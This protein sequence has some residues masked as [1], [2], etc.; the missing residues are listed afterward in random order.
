M[1]AITVPL[2]GC[3]ALSIPDAGSIPPKTPA[4]PE[5]PAESPTEK[6]TP[7]AP[8][9]TSDSLTFAE[10]AQIA[11]GTLTQ[12]G[13]GLIA[14]DGWTMTSPDDGAG[15]WGYTTTDGACT[16]DFWQGTVYDMEEPDDQAASEL[17][18]ASL[19]QADP[20]DVAEHAD[21]GSFSFALSGRGNAD[22]R[23]VAGEDGDRTWVIAAR[24]FAQTQSAVYVVIDCVDGQAESVA[25]DVWEKSAVVVG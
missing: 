10:G 16:A 18:L 22:Q 17:V 6:P 19:L 4:A 21:T 25:K 2:S 9:L 23:F 20:A 7:D 15:S 12:W 3:I 11:P 14:D 5:P 13:D 24:G 8:A 1:L